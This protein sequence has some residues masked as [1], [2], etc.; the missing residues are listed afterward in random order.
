MITLTAPDGVGEVYAGDDLVTLLLT[1]T[2]PADGDIVVVTSKVVSK[3]EDRSRDS[4][5]EEELPGQ[6][7]RVLARRGA[8]TIVR[9]LL[10]LT[11]AAAGIDASNVRRGSI[12]LLPVDPDAS[13]AA[14]RAEIAR[15]TGANVAVVISDTAGRAWRE[16][17][18]DIAIG[19]AGLRVLEE[20]AGRSDAYGNDLVVTAPAVADELASAAELATGKLGMRPFTLISG[21]GDLVLP[22]DQDGPGAARLVRDEGRDFFGFGARE[23][24][25]RALAGAPADRLPF[26]A[27]ADPDELGAA[28]TEV[29]G[30]V[31]HR[32]GD[33]LD[34]D[35]PADRALAA[36]AF[37]HGWKVSG[38]VTSSHLSPVT[39]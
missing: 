13:A 30:V 31:P 18:T 10:G 6:T 38:S 34:V 32:A 28:I 22:P 2:S 11:M 26:G 7:V 12:L 20:F 24:V 19:A 27:P 21:R 15:R 5:R 4:T 14:M 17:Q 9:N 39:Q 25:T 8:T 29:F 37:A 36:L 23:A 35:L 16:G 1:H 33:T 3:A